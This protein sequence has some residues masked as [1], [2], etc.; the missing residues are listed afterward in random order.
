MKHFLS[1]AVLTIA[2]LSGFGSSLAA[3][4]DGGLGTS[5]LRSGNA[6]IVEAFRFAYARSAT[7]RALVDSI[8][9]SR[10]IVYLEA[11]FPGSRPFRSSLQLA[12]GS[13]AVR[14][15]RIDID[16]HQP[17]R[18]VVA[19]LAHELQHATEVVSRPDV[20][21]AQSLIDLY[22]QIG[23]R[24]CQP[25]SGECWET[26]QA[27]AIERLVVDETQRSRATNA[28]AAHDDDPNLQPGRGR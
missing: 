13:G 17:Q 23:Y 9:S 18:I 1:A 3:A 5:Q 28:V 15:L 6:R 27:R 11:E 20:V 16:V 2:V 12:S 19:Q 8:E 26:L 10:D 4:S 14:Y 25:R 22:R 7:F 24:S 21:D